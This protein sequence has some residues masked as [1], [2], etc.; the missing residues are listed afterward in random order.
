M[1]LAREL[2]ETNELASKLRAPAL[3]AACFILLVNLLSGCSWITGFFI[4]NQTSNVLEITYQFR[5]MRNET[6]SCFDEHF[7]PIPSIVPIA[8]LRKQGTEWRKLNQNEYSCDINELRVRFLLEPNMAVGVG[9]EVNYLG[10]GIDHSGINYHLGIES[11]MLRGDSGS[12]VYEG[13]Q[14]I[15]GFRKVDRTRYILEYE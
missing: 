5:K 6:G 13:P 8:D 11:L 9:Y 15:R 4:A 12:I 1:I 14:V 7:R 10:H 3:R 2:R